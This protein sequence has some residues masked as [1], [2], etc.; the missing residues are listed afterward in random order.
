MR[1]VWRELRRVHKFQSNPTSSRE[2]A[3]RVWRGCLSCGWFQS[4]PTSSRE[5]AFQR[6]RFLRAFLGFN[7]TRPVAGNMRDLG[8]G[9]A[10]KTTS[11]QSNPTSSREYAARSRSATRPAPCF[12]P[13]RPVAGNMRPRLQA[14]DFQGFFLCFARTRRSG[15]QERGCRRACR[16]QVPDWHGARTCRGFAGHSGFAQG[17]IVPT[18]AL[19]PWPSTIGPATGSRKVMRTCTAGSAQLSRCL[20]RVSR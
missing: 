4:N 20:I 7:P 19:R 14:I 13:T 3:P 5:Y 2:Y 12:N 11:F 15:S 18:P 10:T 6:W 1:T 17:A 9:A 8:G 16:V